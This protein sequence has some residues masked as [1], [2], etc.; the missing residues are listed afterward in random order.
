MVELRAEMRESILRQVRQEVRYLV[1]RLRAT[2]PYAMF[3]TTVDRLQSAKRLTDAVRQTGWESLVVVGETPV[4]CIH[5]IDSDSGPAQA[6]TAFANVPAAL[7]AAVHAAE[8][9]ASRDLSIED[10]S[11]VRVGQ[12][13]IMVVWVPAEKIVV[14]MRL[15]YE[16]RDL[17][18]NCVYS[19]VQ[20]IRRVLKFASEV[21]SR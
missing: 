14:P 21:E 10:I 3:T 5:V 1:Q 15:R 8:R 9:A 7:A 6:A 19:E 12:L 2:E 4:A 11:V 20:F 17:K 16:R 13:G 18:P